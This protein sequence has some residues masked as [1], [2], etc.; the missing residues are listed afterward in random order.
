MEWDCGTKTMEESVSNVY[1]REAAAV[2]RERT[3]AYAFSHQVT[4]HHLF[5]SLK[6]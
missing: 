4:E 1:L 2:K 5:I 3:M 6:L